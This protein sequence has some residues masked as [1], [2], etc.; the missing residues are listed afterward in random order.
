M[1]YYGEVALRAAEYSNVDSVKQNVKQ[2]LITSRYLTD[3]CTYIDE[4]DNLSIVENSFFHLW[5]ANEYIQ[6]TYNTHKIKHYELILEENGFQL[7]CDTT[8]PIKIDIEGKKELKSLY[9]NIAKELFQEYL[10]AEDRNQDRL[11]RINQSIEY[12]HLTTADNKTLEEFKDIILDKNKMEEHDN[13]IR[14]LRS[15]DYLTEK[16]EDIYNNSYAVRILQSAIHKIKIIRQLENEFDIGF[17]NACYDENDE[18]SMT[19]DFFLSAQTLFRK[20][21]EKQTTTFI[22]FAK[23]KNPKK[24][25]TK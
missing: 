18:I 22:E 7:H 20:R 1:Y 13:L 4:N 10:M 23:K 8:E 16:F 17:M 6:D 5:C 25:Q 12:S 19:D 11:Q 3:S 9:D 24:Q 2:S 15:A 21:R 14:L